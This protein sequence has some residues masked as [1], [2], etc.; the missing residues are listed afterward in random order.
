MKTKYFSYAAWAVSLIG[1]MASCQSPEPE[2]VESNYEFAIDEKKVAV[3]TP[4]PF[5]FDDTPYVYMAKE[6]QAANFSILKQTNGSVSVGDPK[7]IDL[8][9]QLTKALSE[10]VTLH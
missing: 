1:L 2:I 3:D 7:T 5:H 4:D 9:V 6:D 8:K 10:E